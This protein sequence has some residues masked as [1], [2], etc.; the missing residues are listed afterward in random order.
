MCDLISWRLTIVR[1]LVLKEWVL[2][3]SNCGTVLLLHP[4]LLTSSLFPSRND[5]SLLPVFITGGAFWVCVHRKSRAE[6]AGEESQGRRRTS[7]DRKRLH[8]GSGNVHWEDHGT[9]AAGTGRNWETEL[10]WPWVWS[11]RPEALGYRRFHHRFIW[12]EIETVTV[13]AAVL[14]QGPQHTCVISLSLQ[15]LSLVKSTVNLPATAVTPRTTPVSVASENS[16]RESESRPCW[17][18]EWWYNKPGSERLHDSSTCLY[19]VYPG[20]PY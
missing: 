5:T 12:F 16:S 15:H 8:S 1:P 13:S 4:E 18:A 17:K 14:N 20:N 7:S 11:S 6:D 19:R 10:V 9:P 2:F 3:A